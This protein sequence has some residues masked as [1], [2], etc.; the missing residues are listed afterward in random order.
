MTTLDYLLGA[1]EVQA[2]LGQQS[3]DVEDQFLPSVELRVKE[4]ITQPLNYGLTDLY[5]CP[6]YI[7]QISQCSRDLHQN[8]CFF[9]K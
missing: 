5:L 4:H 9:L 2:H 8:H 7:R 1:A 3:R 6:I